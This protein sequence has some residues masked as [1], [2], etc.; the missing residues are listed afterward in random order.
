MDIR[1]SICR[2]GICLLAR[3]LHKL[4]A[5][6]DIEIDRWWEREKMGRGGE[7]QR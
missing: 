1:G 2:A 7:G 3:D 6:L 4:T 5:A